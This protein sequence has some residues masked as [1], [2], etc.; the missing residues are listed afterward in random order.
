MLL[1]GTGMMVS[2]EIYKLPRT[3]THTQNPNPQKRWPYINQPNIISLTTNPIK[4]KTLLH[5]KITIR[6]SIATCVNKGVGHTVA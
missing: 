5:Y 3:H 4:R 6:Q 1:T 2:C